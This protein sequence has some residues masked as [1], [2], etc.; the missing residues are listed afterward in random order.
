MVRSEKIDLVHRVADRLKQSQSIVL[1]NYQGLTVAEM[2]GL[3][4]K[5]R[6]QAVELRVIKN[7]L[8]RRAL[9]EAGV[10]PLDDLLRGNTVVA[11]G[12]H[13]AVA[14]AKV[15]SEFAKEN[16]K[17]VIKGGLLE[18]KRLDERAVKNLAGMPG[19]K[20][21]LAMMARDLKQPATQ[22]ATAMQAGLLKIAYAMQ[23]LARKLE[24]ASADAS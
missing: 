20:E 6:A 8:I 3:R 5:L 7:R 4:G 19:R 10:D 11:F 15:L 1:A 18:G 14:P 13:D 22:V 17:L 23:A 21:L 24:P 12:L 2:T 9:A 16:A